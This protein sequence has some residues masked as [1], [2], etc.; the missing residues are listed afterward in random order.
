MLFDADAGHSTF[1]E[2]V[3]ECEAR[4]PGGYWGPATIPYADVV[5][6]SFQSIF[7]I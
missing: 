4:I 6:T 2:D 7:C 3:Y 5:S 1:L